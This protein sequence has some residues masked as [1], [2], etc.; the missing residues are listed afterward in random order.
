MLNRKIFL[1]LTCAVLFLLAAGCSSGSVGNG[2][3]GANTGGEGQ[4]NNAVRF[5]G[6]ERGP[7]LIG[8]VKTIV[9]NKLTVYKVEGD[10]ELT[11]EERQQQRSRMQGL[12]PEERAKERAERFKVSEE[13][14]DI[15]IPVGVPIIATGNLGGDVAEVD[16]SD[17]KKNDFLRLWFEEPGGSGGE[18]RAE[19]VQ[20]FQGG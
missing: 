7:D 1:L 9:G 16:M 6:P 2:D 15:L 17:I 13:T 11:E 20:I 10:F 18:M 5:G 12:S 3:S 14:A 4:S 19:F 8:K